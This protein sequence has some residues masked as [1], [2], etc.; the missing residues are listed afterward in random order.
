MIDEPTEP[1]ATAARTSRA[2]GW[3]QA[4]ARGVRFVVILYVCWGVALFFL[5]SKMLY[6]PALAGRGLDDTEIAA[7]ERREGLQRHWLERDGERVEAWLLRATRSGASRGLVSI[8]HGNAEL[9][10]HLLDDA[11]QWR[12]LGFDVV[13][14]EYRGYGRSTG[15]PSQESIV[16]D[17]LAAIS[18]ALAETGQ[19]TLVL[20]G[21]SLGT[22]VAVQVAARVGEIAPKPALA[23]AALE[24]PF[25]SVASFA[26]RYGVPP[27]IVRD[28]YRTDLVLPSLDCP[29]L[30]LHARDDEI[31]PIAHGHAL[32]ALAPSRVRLVEL[33]GTHN[34]GISLSRDYW[35]AIEKAAEEAIAPPADH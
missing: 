16:G 10:D 23:F 3:R 28:P 32:A 31:V 8:S 26:P 15:S 6:M 7:L 11:R 34:S 30:I 35:A 12:R 18:W 1:T 5:Q 9:I 33:D 2:R 27:F 21:R 13:L 29:V 14:P 19:S 22:G 4:L 17:T 20:H 24:A 25:T